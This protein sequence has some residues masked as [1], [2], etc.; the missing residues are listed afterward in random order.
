MQKTIVIYQWPCYS[1][2]IC[3]QTDCGGYIKG[4]YNREV[5]LKDKLFSIT[6]LQRWLLTVKMYG[7]KITTK[8][9]KDFLLQSVTE[10]QQLSKT[11][12]LSVSV[13]E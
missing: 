5:H 10:V 12:P 1:P 7:L 2:N 4:Q 3:T 11:A 8:I 9:Q 13:T 6:I